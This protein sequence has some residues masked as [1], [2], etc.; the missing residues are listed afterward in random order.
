MIEAYLAQS[1]FGFCA[2][3]FL[4][5]ATTGVVVG[6]E[7]DAP[8]WITSVLFARLGEANNKEVASVPEASNF[9]KSEV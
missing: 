5:T 4:T 1:P 2:T 7:A 8:T 3:G 6:M 9:T